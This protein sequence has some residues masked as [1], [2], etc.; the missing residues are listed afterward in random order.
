MTTKSQYGTDYFG[1]GVWSYYPDSMLIRLPLTPKELRE[2]QLPDVLGA[3]KSLTNRELFAGT[4]SKSKLFFARCKHELD[5]LVRLLSTSIG[6]FTH[7]L[8]SQLPDQFRWIVEETDKAFFDRYEPL[9]SASDLSEE[10]LQSTRTD[11]H[12]A[13]RLWY[14]TESLRNGLFDS[15]ESESQYIA[16]L[17]MLNWFREGQTTVEVEA[18][19]PPTPKFGSERLPTTISGRNILEFFAVLKEMEL[20]PPPVNRT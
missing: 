19:W 6:L 12:A 18:D 16:A 7:Q 5:H 10:E 20:P 13:V 4:T 14:R 1:G 8:D 3:E 2:F 11:R 15:F 9:I 17:T